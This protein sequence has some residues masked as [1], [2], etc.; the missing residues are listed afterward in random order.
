MK[1]KNMIKKLYKG[2]LFLFVLMNCTDKAN[3][4]G[5]AAATVGVRHFTSVYD[6]LDKMAVPVV[7]TSDKWDSL[8]TI[9]VDKYGIG[10]SWK[11]T[12]NHPYKKLMDSERYK[13]IVF[14]SI[15]ETGAPLLVTIDSL[16]SVIDSLSLL[17]DWSSNDAESRTIETATIGSD[18]SIR[19]LDS[20]FTYRLG[21]EGDR[22][23]STQ[24][25]TVT[26]ELY[27]VLDNGTISRIR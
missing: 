12:L 15:D 24:K 20:V 8:Y 17:G 16:G 18:F 22:L 4:T 27:R 7:L 26:D 2:L 23:E 13:A 11:S 9:H 5:S 10:G 14:V 6:S 1:E 25:L 3:T 21:P 19:L